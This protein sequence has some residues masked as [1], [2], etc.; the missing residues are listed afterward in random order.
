MTLHV[1]RQTTF[2][3]PFKD[4][5]KGSC[6]MTEIVDLNKLEKQPKQ[7]KVT[8]GERKLWLLLT[9]FFTWWIPS[10][11]LRCCG[12]RREE[13]RMAWR[14]KITINILIF[15]TCA[16][17]LL[18]IIGL[19]MIICPKVDILSI[20]EVETYNTTNKPYVAA[21]GRYYDIREIYE[22]HVN[23]AIGVE[24]FRMQEILGQ[25]VSQM[26]FPARNWERNCPGIPNP[27][28]TWD[29]LLE[30]TPQKFWPHYVTD[31]KTG[32][33]VNYLGYLEKYAKGRIGWMPEVIQKMANSDS[34]RKIIRI[35]DNVYDVASYFTASE[36]FFDDNM[37]KI[38]SMFAGKDASAPMKNL[39]QQNP[40]Y[41]RRVL[42]CMN[43]I[44]Y[45]G[46]VDNRAS[47]QCV[48]SNYILVAFSGVMA[49][50]I[51]FKFIFAIVGSR[52]HSNPEEVDKYVLIQ[53]PCYTEGSD[54][55]LGT[56]NSIAQTDYKDTHKLM[57]VVCD[58]LI[59]GDGN[60]K[61]TPAIVLDL[62]YDGS[63]PPQPDS[64]S[65][66]AIGEGVR[67]LN[68][69][70]V[71]SG[72]YEIRGHHLPFIVVVKCGTE[73][74]KAKPGNRGKR[75]S[76]VLLM[77]FL[78]RVYSGD[79]MTPLELEL[80]HHFDKVLGV[81]PKLF[82]YFAMVDADTE[83][84]PDSL[85]KLVSAMISDRQ[86]IG[87]CGETLV[88]NP[89][90]SMTTR[91]QVYEYF[92]SHHLGK[93]FESCFGSV[94]CLP[95]C[96]CMYR[97]RSQ[98]QKT[99]KPLL[100]APKILRDYS[101]N[102]VDTLHKK[103]LLSL[104][105]DRYLTTLML[106]H[107]ANYKTIFVPDAHCRTNVPEYWSVFVS[108]RR[109]WI[110]ST[111]HNLWELIGLSQLCGCCCV[112]MRFV[113]MLEL[114]A[115][116][117]APATVLYLGY[118]LTMIL[119][120]R[121]TVPTVALMILLGIYMLQAVII[122][123]KHQWQ[124]V[125]FMLFYI[126]ATPVFSLWL[127]C[128]SFWHMDDF[129]WGN[130][131]AVVENGQVIE[132]SDADYQFDPST[133]PRLTYQQFIVQREMTA[134][135][136]YRSQV[137]RTSGGTSVISDHQSKVPDF[138]NLASPATLQQLYAVPPDSI[139]QGNY[140]NYSLP[141]YGMYGQSPTVG[142]FG[143]TPEYGYGYDAVQA[144]STVGSLFDNVD[145]VNDNVDI[146]VHSSVSNVSRARSEKKK[147]RKKRAADK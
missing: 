117:V 31:D 119:L 39:V 71:Y 34:P 49:L 72:V 44:F 104:G 125:I 27:G 3:R 56:F 6:K 38:F 110:N 55:L 2:Q 137:H 58:G 123:W 29:N 129:S 22:S 19:P 17:V 139:G 112:S 65:Y 141:H 1:R 127:P 50:V 102:T 143:A 130:T 136:N 144:M 5:S 93:S 86:I 146:D 41:Y 83:L 18:F 45:V 68:K 138:K 126:V 132:Y 9:W 124:H 10:F 16:S 42:N 15:L 103:N 135:K 35:Y 80:Y 13:V 66:Q 133:I 20:Y 90:D 48:L 85:N 23:G 76:Q 32:Q 61:S 60:E 78:N 73:D 12:M 100:V 59:T 14:E 25:D 95:G 101:E 79:A 89:R 91:I 7:V 134:M 108:Q 84:L 113:I 64:L 53:V 77:R 106:K 37:G 111:V 36:P 128:Y 21:Y 54:S 52:Q 145:N 96:F 82:E 51:V 115:T 105:E 63:P 70:G 98:S 43:R 24:R 57:V 97:I 46:T 116:V 69:A 28:P 62:L 92:I 87:A 147:R 109:R 75:D 30:R 142:P 131:R 140:P 33:T 4:Y 8:S 67:E 47:L 88:T 40:A 74:E 26:F 11:I 94:T 122:L 120:D 81:D 99:P 107:F 121:E 114:L 118:L